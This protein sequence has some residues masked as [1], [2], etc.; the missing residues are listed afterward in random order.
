IVQPHEQMPGEIRG[1]AIE[2]GTE[3]QIAKGDVLTI[4][5]GTPHWFKVVR[6]P[7]RYYVIKSSGASSDTNPMA[8]SSGTGPVEAPLATIDLGSVAGVT[9][10]NGSW[11]YSDARIVE[12]TFRA[13]DDAGQPTGREW[14]T[15]DILPHAGPADF[16]DSKWQAIEPTS[17]AARR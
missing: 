12:T 5:N 14:T 13:P 1:S 2:G 17:L 11:R 16:D 4:P 3:Q 6:T 15:N 10:V 9:A 7:F 8:S